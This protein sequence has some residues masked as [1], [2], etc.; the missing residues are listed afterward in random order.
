MLFQQIE[1]NKRKTVFFMLFFALLVVAVGVAVSYA[2]AADPWP[3]LLITAVLMAVY[4]PLTYFTASQQVLA[5]SGAR[6]ITE[7]D[8]PQLY[9][10]VEELTLAARLPMPK[11]YVIEDDSPNAFATGIKPEKA[12][13]AFTTGLLTRLNREELEGVTAHELSHIRNYDIRLMTICIALVGVITILVE[14]GTRFLYLRDNRNS[15]QK[16]NPILMVISILVIILAPLAAQ[17]V[18]LAVSRNR[19]YLA[20]ANAVEITR[21]S[22]GLKNALIKISENP[23]KVKRATKATAALYIANPLGKKRER[24]SLFSTHPPISERIARLEMM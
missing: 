3:G 4:L 19:E 6:E 24:T 11:V 17:F 8:N 21:N 22:T 12:A 23:Q 13:V 5:M 16:N 14:Y 9:H 18:Q 2:Y 20:D 7:A 10:I 15:Q 1:Q